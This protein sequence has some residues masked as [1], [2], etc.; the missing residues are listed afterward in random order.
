MPP[1]YGSHLIRR[2]KGDNEDDSVLIFTIGEQV[3]DNKI[4]LGKKF[5]EEKYQKRPALTI[6]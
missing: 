4:V 3:L 5:D 1:G 2:K 6:G